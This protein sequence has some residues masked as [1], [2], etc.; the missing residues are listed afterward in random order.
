MIARNTAAIRVNQ[1]I[2]KRKDTDNEKYTINR[3]STV[4]NSL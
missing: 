2:N 3:D 1:E 4:E